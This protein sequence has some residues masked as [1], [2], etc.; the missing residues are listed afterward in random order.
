MKKSFLS[1]LVT[2][3]A[4]LGL[5]GLVACSSSDT[6]PVANDD[7]N[8]TQVT[9]GGAAGN[10]FSPAEVTIKVGEKVRWTFQSGS[11]NVVAGA[12]CSAP[13]AATFSSGDPVT[14][15]TFEH[16][17]D[18]AGDFPYQCTNHCTM[19]MTGVVHVTP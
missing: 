1:T 2:S 4:A 7:A 13:D 14:S 9:V 19:G 18:K 6:D 10:Q 3:T 11:H 5:V 8:V 17:F 12:D 16:L 15:G